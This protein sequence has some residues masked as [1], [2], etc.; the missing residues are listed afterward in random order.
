MENEEQKSVIKYFWMKGWRAKWICEELLNALS[1]DAY[2]QSHSKTWS[3]KF[4]T[5]NL[6]CQ[7]LPRAGRALLTLGPQL[8]VFLGKYRFATSWM[9]LRHF[10]VSMPTAKAILRRELGIRKL[11]R[12]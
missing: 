6:S 8:E 9:I 4:K 3:Q 1:A 10:R 7:D 2:G 12:R 11:S 5:D